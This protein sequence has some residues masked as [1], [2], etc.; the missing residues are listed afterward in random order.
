VVDGHALDVIDDAF[1]QP[2]AR[3]TNECSTA[4]DAWA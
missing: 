3:A 2:R 4:L 1:G